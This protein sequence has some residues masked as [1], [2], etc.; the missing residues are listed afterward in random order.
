MET[1]Q[2]KKMNMRDLDPREEGRERPKPN[3][4]LKRIHIGAVAK[5]FT[6]IRRGLLEAMKADLMNLLR[7]NSNLFALAPKDMPGID[8]RVICHRLA[9]DPKVRLVAQKKRK[10]GS[11]KQK[12]TMKE[13]EKLL[14]VE[15]IKEIH[16]TT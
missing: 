4:K 8:L 5:K 14:K 1:D 3:D 11:K 9:I 16:F 10:L 2:N 7:R 13:T 12:A 6:F 15:F